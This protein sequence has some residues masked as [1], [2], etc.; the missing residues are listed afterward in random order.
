[1]RSDRDLSTW[2]VGYS[3]GLNSSI[4]A[5]EAAVG[6]CKARYCRAVVNF[7]NACGAVAQAFNTSGEGAGIAPAPARRTAHHS[8]AVST[9][10]AAGSSAGYVADRM[11]RSST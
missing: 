2:Q 3:E 1:M 4:E 7:T 11:R 9:A 5:E 6:L 10:P 8:H